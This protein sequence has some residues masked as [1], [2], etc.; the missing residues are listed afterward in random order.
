MKIFLPLCTLILAASACV[1]AA[2]QIAIETPQAAAT[3]SP[4]PT[5]TLA[6]LPPSPTH[7]PTLTPA[8]SVPALT[9]DLLRNAEYA[10][11]VSQKTVKLLEGRYQA[12]SGTDY[13]DV[14]MITPV[15]FG[16]LDGDGTA[17]AAVVLGENTGG[18]GTFESLVVVL[19][20]DGSPLQADTVQIGDRVRVNSITIED[21][22]IT[23]DEFVRGPQ[24]GMCCPSQ[25]ET[26]IYRYSHAS[27]WVSRL[28]TRTPQGAERAIQ[29]DSPLD[30]AQV[31]SSLL[32]KGSETI[33]P[34]ENN[35]V[36][37]LDSEKNE[38]LAKGSVTANA[39]TPGGP[40]VF[41]TAIDLS[42]LPAGQVFR[43]SISDLSA[44]DGAV[45]ARSS[46]EL[47]RK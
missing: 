21:Q 36:Y 3:P 39:S 40:A 23:L 8:A 31:G 2:P 42:S 28:M 9:M 27:L 24:D 19:N 16:D 15:G 22:K 45:L 10:L 38:P 12:G 35:L 41:E 14:V 46:I 47:V 30:G 33:A 5:S 20:R 32:V 34:F 7:T 29:I 17:D 26:V 37:Q 44:A 1:P 43:L 25:P 6:A 13:V 11:P 4:A 18:S